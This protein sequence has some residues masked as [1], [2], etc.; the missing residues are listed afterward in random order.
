MAAT[1]YEEQYSTVK[2]GY[3]ELPGTGQ[4]CSL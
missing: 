2:L 4:I 3:N 1:Q